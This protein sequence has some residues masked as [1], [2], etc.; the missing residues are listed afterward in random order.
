MILKKKWKKI[1]KIEDKRLRKLMI[2][3]EEKDRLTYLALKERFEK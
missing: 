3:K 1:K 2:K